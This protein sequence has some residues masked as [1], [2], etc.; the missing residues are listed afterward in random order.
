MAINDD[1]GFRET[2]LFLQF[3]GGRVRIN[4]V[5]NQKFLSVQF[6]DFHE[7]QRNS[8]VRVAEHSGNGRDGSQ[9]QQQSVRAD[10]ARVQDVL[11]ASEDIFDTRV[12]KTVSV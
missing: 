1:V 9:F 5:V 8:H 4:D 7:L 6:D 12:K 10:I 2:N 11:H 3:S